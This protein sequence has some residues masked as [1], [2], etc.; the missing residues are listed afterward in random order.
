MNRLVYES[1]GKQ[2]E[3]RLSNRPVSLG[4]SDEADQQLP[5]KLASRIHAQVFPRERGW[6][7]EDLAS[8]N[9]TIVNGNRIQK[10][11]PLVPG[12]VIT[13]GDVK[14]TYE[15]EAA[16]P[17][18]PPDHLI[19]RIVYTAEKGKPPIDTL[20][21]DR[22]TIGRK[23]DN[24][25]QIDAKVVSGQH[26]EIL[27]RQ[28]AY[29]LRDLNS[30]NGTFIND[31]R[32]TEH[33]LRNGDVI[34][35]GKKIQ[36]YF[37]DPAGASEPQQQPQEPAG[38]PPKG[39]EITPEHLPPRKVAKPGSSAAGASDRGVFKPVGESQAKRKVNPIPHV[40]VGIGLG[41][42]FVLVGWIAGDLL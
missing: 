28:G 13:I 10:P 14:L 7:V 42:L 35:L 34:V 26:C 32:I 18:G 31:E 21:R 20:I 41:A 22:V 25:L 2:H 3:I 17:K 30:S 9:G 8:S 15:G 16:Q 40:A 39:P 11:M 24:S 36:V 29:L 38:G 27:N 6:W 23:P 19:A 37:I 12:D 33:T 1:E 5:T 4:R